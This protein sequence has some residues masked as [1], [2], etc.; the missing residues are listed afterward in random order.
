MF[1]AEYTSEDCTINMVYI[2]RDTHRLLNLTSS[3]LTARGNLQ[4]HECENMSNGSVLVTWS[5]GQ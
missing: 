3:F 5:I 1:M 2:Y 4:V